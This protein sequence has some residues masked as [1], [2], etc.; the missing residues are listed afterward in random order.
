MAPVSKLDRADSQVSIFDV[1]RRYNLPWAEDTGRPRQIRCPMHADSTPSA[2]VYPA[3]NSLYC[4]T[5]QRSAGPVGLVV[6][7]EGC[8]YNDAAEMLA[9]WYGFD[10]AGDPDE[11]AFWALV[12]SY[13]RGEDHRADPGDLA[14][15]AAMAAR[16]VGHSW[17]EARRLLAAYEVL[18]CCA[19]HP[20]EWLEW[21]SPLASPQGE[22]R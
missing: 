6:A 3:T 12:G 16:A 13:E 5:C 4:W 8:G 17:E 20:R 7:I 18:D 15:A 14:R 9:A 19:V 10:L 11:A 1:A 21:V 2:R 22:V